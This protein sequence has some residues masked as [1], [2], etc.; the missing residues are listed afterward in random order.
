[1]ITTIKA[2]RLAEA[3]FSFGSFA[4]NF[5]ND[6]FFRNRMMAKVGAKVLL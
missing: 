4:L 3:F 5:K 6:I 1:M 2:Y